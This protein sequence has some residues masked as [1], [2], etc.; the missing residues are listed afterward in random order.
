MFAVYASEPNADDP[1]DSLVVG[2]RPEPE[3]PDGWVAVNVNA[4]SL[5][6]HD[7]G[8]CGASGSSPSSSR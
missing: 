7:L 1:L 8:R 3:V 4:A 2:E 6:M 5:N